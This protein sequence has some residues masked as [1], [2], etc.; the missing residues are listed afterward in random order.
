[1]IEGYFLLTREENEIRSDRR[2]ASIAVNIPGGG[3]GSL[4]SRLVIKTTNITVISGG[5]GGELRHEN[6]KS[7]YRKAGGGARK[8]FAVG[9]E[10]WEQTDLAGFLQSGYKE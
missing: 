1:M 9:R 5:E 3:G 8:E 7:A 4:N 10:E 2:V 6:H